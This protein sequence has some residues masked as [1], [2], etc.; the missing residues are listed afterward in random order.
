M[1]DDAVGDLAHRAAQVHR[2]LLDPAE[3]LGLGDPEVLLE[4]ALGPVDGLP[5]RE[6]V[7]E[8]GQSIDQIIATKEKEILAI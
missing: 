3:R 4:D 1:L 8:A 5:R 2:R 7:S 6:L